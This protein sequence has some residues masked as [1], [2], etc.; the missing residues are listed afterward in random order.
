MLMVVQA[1]THANAE[2]FSQ[3][4]GGGQRGLRGGTGTDVEMDFEGGV[5]GRHASL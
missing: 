3:P 1:V 4:F 5:L 2:H